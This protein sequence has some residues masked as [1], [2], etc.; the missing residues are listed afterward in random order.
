M[1]NKQIKIGLLVICSA[2]LLT[3]CSGEK[4]APGN[5]I[6][7]TFI[8]LENTDTTNESKATE[9]AEINTSVEIDYNWYEGKRYRGTEK[10]SLF[11]IQ[12]GKVNSSIRFLCNLSDME[13]EMVENETIGTGLKYFYY[14]ETTNT[15]DEKLYDTIIVEYYPTVDRVIITEV[16]NVYKPQY[17]CSDVYE[18]DSMLHENVNNQTDSENTKG[19]CYLFD[20]QRFECFETVSG[21]DITL[22]VHLYYSD[23]S[24]TPS[25]YKGELSNG[26]EFWF[27]PY[28]N[29]S[30]CITYKIDCMD[31]TTAYLEYLP[32]TSEIVLI[33]D[34]G[35]EYRNMYAYSGTYI[36]L[37]DE[38]EE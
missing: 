12:D 20:G 16:D 6:P 24:S 13:I 23:N 28:E 3:A 1:I 37:P 22:T 32:N 31:G 26:V 18:Y 27:E 15:N 30:D 11:W 5:A 38:L 10:G 35:T 33:A 36:G 9:S 7:E 19:A 21:E 29:L 8:E 17:N 14:T 2:T 25:S 4:T 34:E